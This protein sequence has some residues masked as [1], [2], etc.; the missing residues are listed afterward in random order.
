MGVGSTGV[1]AVQLG[2]R[3]IGIEIDP[4]RL[5]DELGDVLF[6][7]SQWAGAEAWFTRGL[8]YAK[9]NRSMAGS[10][11]LGRALCARRSDF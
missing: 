6:A 9:S 5:R 3:F 7:Q 1:A 8:E 11:S 4:D 2:R 10:L